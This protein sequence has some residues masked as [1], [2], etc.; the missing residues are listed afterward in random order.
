MDQRKR[1]VVAQQHVVARH[2]ALDQVAFEQQRLDLGVGETTSSAVR[3][4]HHA[5]QPVREIGEMRVVL[6]PA[7]QIARLADI[8]RVA[9]AVEHAVDAGA[10][11]Q[12]AQRGADHGDAARHPGRCRRRSASTA[13]ATAVL[14]VRPVSLRIP[15]GP[16]AIAAASGAVH[17]RRFCRRVRR[18]VTTPRIRS[19]R[20]LVVLPCIFE[21]RWRYPRNLWI[22]L[23]RNSGLDQ[24]ANQRFRRF[25][26]LPKN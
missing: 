20:Q 18:C 3:L 10:G 16:A 12:R 4:G 21:S 13:C 11:R 14:A 25:P 19:A 2:Q 23:L 17:R 26:A 9:L 7:F 15:S 8:E 6:H 24:A 5:A 22:T 1:L